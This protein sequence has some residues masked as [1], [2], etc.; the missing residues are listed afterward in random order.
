MCKCLFVKY[1]PT[2]KFYAAYS[3]INIPFL[4]WT[5]YWALALWHLPSKAPIDSASEWLNE[6]WGF[7]CI[8]WNWRSFSPF[9]TP[10]ISR[11]QVSWIFE[12]IVEKW[13]AS[14]WKLG[15][16]SCLILAYVCTCPYSSAYIHDYNFC[17]QSSV[18]LVWMANGLFA[19][20][21]TLLMDGER[22]KNVQWYKN[23]CLYATN[24]NWWNKAFTPSQL[25]L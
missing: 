18:I 17:H 10:D 14:L 15:Y 23:I 1:T 25:Q 3:D 22:W 2:L 4:T 8:K 11:F 9:F 7:Y 6:A 13:P 20:R 12:A 5:D 21:N 16:P 19:L 24:N